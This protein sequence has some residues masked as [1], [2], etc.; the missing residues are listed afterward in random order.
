MTSAETADRIVARGIRPTDMKILGGNEQIR[1]GLAGREFPVIVADNVAEYV[2]ARFAAGHDF[3]I[4]GWPCLAPP[5]DVAWIEYTNAQTERRGVWML[6]FDLAKTSPAERGQLDGM[7]GQAIED[8][9]AQSPGEPVRWA[10]VMVLFVDNGREVVGPWG[11]V[12]WVLDGWGKPLGNRWFLRN[13]ASAWQEGEEHESMLMHIA[14]TP[15]L[16][17][18]SF[19]HCRNAVLEH[20]ARPPKLAKAYRRR[21]GA[22]PVRWQTVRLELPRRAGSADPSRPGSPPDLHIVSGHYAHYGNCCPSAHEPNGLLFGRLDGVFW[23]PM[24]MAGDA[25]REVRTDRIVTLGESG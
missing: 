2:R 14:L 13:G 3:T 20:G 6:G 5:W 23:V 15:A 10:I 8:A 24:H 19:A 12:I 22:E 1:E 25:R 18:I 9:E 17:T 16:Q 7:I 4:G 21:H 11:T